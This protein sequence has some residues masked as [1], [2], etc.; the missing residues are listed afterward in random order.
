MG[1]RNPFWA[2]G[3]SPKQARLM[4]LAFETAE[5][6]LD[7][8]D[9]DASKASGVPASKIARWR[10]RKMAEI[11]GQAALMEVEDLEQPPLVDLPTWVATQVLL[12]MIESNKTGAMPGKEAWKI[13][14]EFFENRE[15]LTYHRAHH[16][17]K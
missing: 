17:S 15:R 6:V 12:K 2:Q 13:T 1:K 10:Q 8:S 16:W 3:F 4:G 14:E 11:E 7:M 5:E 9:Q